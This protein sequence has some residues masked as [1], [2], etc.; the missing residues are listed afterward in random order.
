MVFGPQP[1]DI[2]RKRGKYFGSE[3]EGL[4]ITDW[5]LGIRV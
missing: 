4:R 5:G 1:E 2:V 3:S